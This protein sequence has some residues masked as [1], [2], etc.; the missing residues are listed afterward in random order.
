MS[1]IDV[2]ENVHPELDP[3][4]CVVLFC[5]DLLCFSVYTSFAT[6]YNQARAWGVQSISKTSHT[7]SHASKGD[8]TL[9]SGENKRTTGRPKVN[10]LIQSLIN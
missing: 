9:T 7:M 8:T 6:R 1:E 2:R 10:D 5:L 4:P 3:Q